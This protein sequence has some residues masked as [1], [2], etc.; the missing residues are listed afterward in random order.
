[1]YA[2]GLVRTS[3]KLPLKCVGA[4]TFHHC[5]IPLIYLIDW[6][7]L[8]NCLSP[9]RGPDLS[10]FLLKCDDFPPQISSSLFCLVVNPL[11]AD[12][13][14][15]ALHASSSMTSSLYKR[16]IAPEGQSHQKIFCLSPSL[17]F[18]LQGTVLLGIDMALR[19]TCLCDLVVFPC[20]VSAW[21]QHSVG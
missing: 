7:T 17:N 1:M 21:P 14:K 11:N 6:M 13:D 16:L 4:L 5:G 3:R 10:L 9:P 15:Y 19:V 8:N 20:A 18:L 12:K 2:A